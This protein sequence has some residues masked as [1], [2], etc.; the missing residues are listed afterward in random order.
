MYESVTSVT[1]TTTSAAPNH[2]R[3]VTLSMPHK[4]T[5]EKPIVASGTVP[6]IGATR[7]TGAKSSAAHL[8]NLPITSRTPVKIQNIA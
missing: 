1:P 7:L 3:T 2:K 5:Q 4:K 6:K 8:L